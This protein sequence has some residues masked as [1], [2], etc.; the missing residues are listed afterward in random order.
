M[1][2]FTKEDLNSL[3]NI[4]NSIPLKKKILIRVIFIVIILMIKEKKKKR[5]FETFESNLISSYKSCT[6]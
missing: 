2:Y 1:I 5:I 6:V 4:K 3:I